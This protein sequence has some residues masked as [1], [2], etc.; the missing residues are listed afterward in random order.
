MKG[1]NNCFN[2]LTLLF[3]TIEKS[4]LYSK[5]DTTMNKLAVSTSLIEQ[6]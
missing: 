6:N 4:H 2:K 3:E 5:K 1:I